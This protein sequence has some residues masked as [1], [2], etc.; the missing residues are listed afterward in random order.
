MTGQGLGDADVA[1]STFGQLPVSAAAQGSLSTG[2]QL[3]EQLIRSQQ[4]PTLD[5]NNAASNN[6]ALLQQLQQQQQ[7]EQQQQQ[8]AAVAALFGSGMGMGGGAL[9]NCPVCSSTLR[10]EEALSHVEACLANLEAASGL[11]T[12]IRQ[13]QQQEAAVRWAAQQQQQQQAAQNQQQQNLL[14]ARLQQLQQQQQQQAQQNLLA[15]V[16]AG[17]QQAQ[18]MQ[19]GLLR[20]DDFV[21][22]NSAAEASQLAPWMLDGNPAASRPPLRPIRRQ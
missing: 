16:A 15:A 6:F 3:Y 8:Q 22:M 20:L 10:Q 9:L 14:L 12:L 5:A 17:Q 18:Q 1:T 2:V 13:Q 11:E 19:S 7:R 4:Q 21:R